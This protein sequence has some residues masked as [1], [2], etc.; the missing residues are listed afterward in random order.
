M[1]GQTLMIHI[2]YLGFFNN[3]MDTD[4]YLELFVL[5]TVGI[6]NYYRKITGVLLLSER[7]KITFNCF[8]VEEY[9]DLT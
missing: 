7:C 6:D 8:L 4:C 3:N 5:F 9:Q 1:N 2:M